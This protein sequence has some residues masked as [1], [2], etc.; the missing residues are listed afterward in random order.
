M[1]N[2]VC[3]VLSNSIRHTPVTADDIRLKKAT[4]EVIRKVTNLVKSNLPT[5]LLEGELLD[6]ISNGLFFSVVDSCLMLADRVVI[7]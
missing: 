3:L 7:L 2:G 5:F 1:D 6:F 4:D